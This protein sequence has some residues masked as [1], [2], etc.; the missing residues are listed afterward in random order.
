VPLERAQVPLVD[1]QA[2][3]GRPGLKS[4]RIVRRH[5]AAVKPDIVHTHLGTSDLIAGLAARSLGLPAVSTLH[6]AVWDRTPEVRLKR[7]LVK[8]CASRIIAV[9]DSARRAYEENGWAKAGQIVMIHN[10]ADVVAVPGAG[11][12]IRTALGWGPNDL[13]VAMVSSLRP[14]KAHDVAISA[15][16]MLAAEFPQLRLLIVGEGPEEPKIA[17]LAHDLGDRVAMVGIRLDVMRY[18]DA[19]DV[20]LHPSR[21]DA[22]P[23]TLIEAMAAA[24]PVLATQVGGIPEIV[25]D[26]RTGLLVDAPPSAEEVAPALASLLRDPSWRLT[27][28]TAARAAYQEEFTARRWVRVTRATYD[29]VLAES[30]QHRFARGQLSAQRPIPSGDRADG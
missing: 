30:R 23:T 19:C 15:V 22:F 8:L 4:L 27:L 6:T 28:A 1:L 20:C 13:V 18:L 17:R 21:A 5:F 25:A 2:V 24:V 11:R 12:E 9:S 7:T 3:D 26:R 14:E 10:G 29:A 16:R